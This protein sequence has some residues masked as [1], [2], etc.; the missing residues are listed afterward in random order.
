MVR[1]SLLVMPGWFTRDNIADLVYNA[2]ILWRVWQCDF[3]TL[4]C[5]HASVLLCFAM[6]LFLSAWLVLRVRY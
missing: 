1:F 6:F 2:Y 3:L 4:S 5:F